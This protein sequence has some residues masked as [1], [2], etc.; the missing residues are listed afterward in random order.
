MAFYT[1]TMY[2]YGAVVPNSMSK[3]ERV[4]REVR[5]ERAR[6]GVQCNVHNVAKKRCHVASHCILDASLLVPRDCT[7]H[8]AVARRSAS[9]ADRKMRGS[10]RCA[11]IREDAASRVDNVAEKRSHAASHASY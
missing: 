1:S 5:C 2:T 8:G 9:C 3:D 11:R 10:I 6:G 4:R 7:M